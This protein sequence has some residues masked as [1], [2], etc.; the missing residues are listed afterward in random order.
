LIAENAAKL[1]ADNYKK[2]KINDVK[3]HFGNLIFFGCLS[4]KFN[5]PA[6]LVEALNINP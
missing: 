1:F 5:S 4:K 2:A 3:L 6:C